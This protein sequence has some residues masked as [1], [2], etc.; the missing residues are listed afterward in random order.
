MYGRSK[1]GEAMNGLSADEDAPSSCADVLE[2]ALLN[3]IDYKGVD[4]NRVVEAIESALRD[5]R[6][7][8]SS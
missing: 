5:L 1:V 6:S 3:L 7:T 4:A 2:L 8:A